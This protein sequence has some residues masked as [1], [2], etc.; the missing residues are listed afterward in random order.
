MPEGDAATEI[1]E[2]M[3]SIVRRLRRSAADGVADLPVTPAQARVVEVL[4]RSRGPLRVNQVAEQ[5]GILPRSAT[6][7]LDDLEE[8]QLIRRSPDRRDRR[9]VLVH[10]T[11]SGDEL[12]AELTARA[13]SVVTTRLRSLPATDQEILLRILTQL[14]TDLDSHSV[15]GHRRISDPPAGG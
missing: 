15:V 2:Q 3:E 7:V 6:S 13:S 14:R 11:T 1:V 9:A 5:L 8:G 10:L 4:R 12:G